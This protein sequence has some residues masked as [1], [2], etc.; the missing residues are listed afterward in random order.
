MEVVAQVGAQVGMRVGVQVGAHPV[1]VRVGA[2]VGT[3]VGAHPGGVRVG[4]QVGVQVGRRAPDYMSL[5]VPVGVGV[6]VG[7]A[8]PGWTGPLTVERIF[9]VGCAALYIRAAAARPHPRM[10]SRTFAELF[11][12]APCTMRRGGS[13]RISPLIARAAH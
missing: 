8:A 4:G 3:R 9:L 11:E 13:R 5:G 7:D 10:L 2:Q 6:L 1:G 12:R